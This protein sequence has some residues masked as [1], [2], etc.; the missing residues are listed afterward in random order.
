M[1][2]LEIAFT[3]VSIVL[4]VNDRAKI[5]ITTHKT[6]EFLFNR[7]EK[8]AKSGFTL[9]STETAIIPQFP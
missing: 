2:K 6:S 9:S 4:T 5:I 8:K 7:I 1:I 3:K